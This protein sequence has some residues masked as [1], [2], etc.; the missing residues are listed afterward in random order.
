MKKLLL[1][2]IL[3][4][5]AFIGLITPF[6]I[7][8]LIKKNVWFKSSTDTLKISL[9]VIVG[10]CYALVLVIKALAEMNKMVKPLITLVVISVITYLFQNIVNDLFII[11]VSLII[12]YVVFL[13]LYTL[14]NHFV[15]YGTEF[16]KTYIREEAKEEYQKQSK[17][18]G[19]V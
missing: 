4:V 7:L 10:M 11:L 2:R 8:C 14:A 18:K 5:V 9:G 16:K 1:G 3:Q 19:N 12:G 6:F 13:I 15:E 17:S